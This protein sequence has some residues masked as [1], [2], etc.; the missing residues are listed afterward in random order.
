MA[1]K[2][3]IIVPNS[4]LRKRSRPIKKIDKKIEGLVKDLIDT[5]KAAKEPEGVGLSA[6]QIGKLARIFVVKQGGKFVPFINPKIT[7][8]SKKMFS[9]ILKKGKLF[10]E[11][12][13]SIPNY[14][15]FVDRPYAV[16]LKWQ[17]L[18]GKTHQRKFENKESAYVQHES[19]HLNGILFVD[20]TLK[21][22]GKTYKLEKDKEGKEIF[23]EVKIE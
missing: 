17:D 18:K 4:L 11:G 6:I 21:Q 19:D 8:R 20:R 23:V 1:I 14:Y 2:E 10:L 3:V 9:Q 7:W 22:Q 12:C 5:V 15:G 16:K 13:L